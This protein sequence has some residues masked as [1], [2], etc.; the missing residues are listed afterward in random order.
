[1]GYELMGRIF[2]ATSDL[3]DIEQEPKIVG[4]KMFALIAPK[5]KSKNEQS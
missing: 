5:G 1:M 2:S 3:A 4:K